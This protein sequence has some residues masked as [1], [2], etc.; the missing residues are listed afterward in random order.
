MLLILLIDPNS[1]YDLGFL[2]SVAATLGIVCAV[3]WGAPLPE[4][5]TRPQR[6]GHRL[7]A[8]VRVT[9]AAT[10]ATMPIIAFTFQKLPVLSPLSN[11]IGEPMAS[12]LVVCGCIGTLLM[13]VPGLSFLASPFYLVAGVLA[14][15]MLS[16]ARWIASWPLSVWLLNAPYMLIWVCAA[17]FAL[18]LGWWLLRRRGV[19]LSAMLLVIALAAASLTYTLGMRGVVTMTMTDLGDGTALLLARDGHYGLVL[20]GQSTGRESAFL[21]RR[22]IDRLDFVVYT[23]RQNI[24]AS[25]KLNAAC[26]MTATASGSTMD[27][28][29]DGTATLHNGWLALTFGE[30]R[31]LLCPSAGD[32]A[33]LPLEE[34]RADVLIFDH[35]PPKHVTAIAAGEAVLCCSEE[36][37]LNVTRAMPWGAY[38]VALTKDGAVTRR[39]RV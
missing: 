8:A 34:R 14:R 18:L 9:L 35:T 16:W 15:G 13:C 4:D 24:A 39:I 37:V 23:E 5:A 27:F 30:Q 26:V 6:I 7:W 20:T 17:P 21:S 31:V 32:A 3:S 11:L 38:P 2:L 36:E 33:T 29:N 25:P 1:V 10:I 19:H 12:G 28:W 22:G